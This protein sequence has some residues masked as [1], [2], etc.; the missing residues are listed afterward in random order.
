[1]HTEKQKHKLR[2]FLLAKDIVMIALALIGIGLSVFEHFEYIH[3]HHHLVWVD[4]FEILVGLV[5]ATE[6]FFEL[7]HAKD[8]KLY[9]KQHWIY[10]LAS[11]PIPM[12]M[13]E[14]MRGIR[15][16]RLLRLIKEFAH[17]SYEH[18]TWLFS[19]RH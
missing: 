4:V 9:W 18:N 16:L 3:K 14:F 5:F 1:M 8:K 2:G 6:F 13:I 15:A 12:Q 11:I 7:H 19:Q 10:L 17:L